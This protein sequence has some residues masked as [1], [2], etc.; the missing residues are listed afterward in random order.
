MK[1]YPRIHEYSD[2][3][4]AT[5]ELLMHGVCAFFRA[6]ALAFA[7]SGAGAV[8]GHCFYAGNHCLP[9]AFYELQFRNHGPSGGGPGG[10]EGLAADFL[11]LFLGHRLFMYG[12]NGGFFRDLFP[13][14]YHKGGRAGFP[15]L[16]G[17]IYGSAGRSLLSRVVFPGH[18]ADAV[19]YDF[20]SGGAVYHVRR[21]ISPGPGAF[22][23]CGLRVPDVLHGNYGRCTFSGA[24]LSLFPRPSE[25]TGYFHY[26][27]TVQGRVETLYFQSGGESVY[28]YGYRAAG[29]FHK[30]YDSRLLQRG[31]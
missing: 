8:W 25:E 31:G 27:Q 5:W 16:S 7:D 4:T 24:P 9:G 12:R 11:G 13:A 3:F 21:D 29:D 1:N 10:G 17:F 23:L 28:D 15:A 30:S 2:G 18:P 26:F 22:G 20:Q 19:Y 6:G 14:P